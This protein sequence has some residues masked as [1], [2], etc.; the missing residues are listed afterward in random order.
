MTTKNPDQSIRHEAA[1]LYSNGDTRGAI[2]LLLQRINASNGWCDTKVWL[3]LLEIYQISGQQDPY[4]KLASVFSSRFNFSA[5]AWDPSA[6][7][8]TEKSA[9]Q[10]RN[11]LVI[12]GSPAKINE[13]KR[14]DFLQ[15]SKDFQSSRLDFSRM[16][17]SEDPTEQI[18]ELHKLLEIMERV[19]KLK[20]PTLFMGETELFHFLT[21]KID[22]LKDLSSPNAADHVY[23]NVL[24]EILQW[25]GDENGHDQ[26]V[27]SF[28]DVYSTCPV[29]FDPNESIAVAPR[30]PE[31]EVEAPPSGEE[32]VLPDIV[33]QVGAMVLFI[34]QQWQKNVPAEFVTSSMKRMT[35]DTARE[36][37]LFLQNNSETHT[38]LDV[39]FLDT[40]ELLTALFEITGIN[41]HAQVRYRH[42]KLRDI[43]K[44]T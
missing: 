22:E 40:G 41:A 1:L 43:Y 27:L 36:L 25:R 5:P 30:A 16:K 29:S 18:E 26:T 39:V 2:T 7:L 21:T 15:A 20:V 34:Q 9:A 3:M 24:L 31:T 32:F 14:R 13:D 8:K 17:L 37:A 10:W 12:D 19:R 38:S 28:M 33:T 42:S 11:A 23:W 6:V 35:A 4:E 44:P